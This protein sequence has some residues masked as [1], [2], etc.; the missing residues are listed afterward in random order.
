V[1]I[2]SSAFKLK[3]RGIHMSCGFK[4]YCESKVRV[5]V[6]GLCQCDSEDFQSHTLK[7]GKNNERRDNVCRHKLIDESQQGYD[8]EKRVWG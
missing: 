2:L 1:W 7:S 3:V 5:M 8:D 4:M 6:N